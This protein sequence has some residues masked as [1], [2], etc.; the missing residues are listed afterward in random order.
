MQRV[1][2]TCGG[3]SKDLYYCEIVTVC[4]V[5]LFA[6]QSTNWHWPPRSWHLFPTQ[7]LRYIGIH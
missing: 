1:Y 7:T 6:D 3:V 4:Q 2:Y 5:R